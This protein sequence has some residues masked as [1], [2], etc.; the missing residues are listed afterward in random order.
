MI[1]NLKTPGRSLPWS[2]SR[3]AT[4]V[5]VSFLA[6]GLVELGGHDVT[7]AVVCF[8]LATAYVPLRALRGLLVRAKEG[9]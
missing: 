6:V 9:R 7:G 3:T 2:W 8:V 5:L 1:R 4:L